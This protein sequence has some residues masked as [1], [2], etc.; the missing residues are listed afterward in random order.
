MPK[1]K[2]SDEHYLMEQ[3]EIPALRANWAHRPT[4]ER[5]ER[6]R[7]LIDKGFSRRA[8]ARGLECSEGLIRQLLQLESL[9]EDEKQALGE[10]SLSLKKALSN[11]H[12]R[13]FAESQCRPDPDEPG[14]ATQAELPPAAAESAAPTANPDGQQSANRTEV[15]TKAFIDWVSNLNLTGPYLQ[16]LFAELDGG[17]RGI[18][19][20]LFARTKPRPE[21]ISLGGD[22]QKVI[23]VCRPKREIPSDPGYISYCVEWYGRWS[24]RL[25]PASKMRHEV[26]YSVAG[27]F[28]QKKWLV[29]PQSF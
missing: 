25:M 29:A 20:L 18:N 9:T 17:P 13:K 23:D 15:V 2:I 5:V 7:A 1:C 3:S 11:V 4:M 27:Y 14:K 22:P 24:R 16:S 6:L 21:E 12:A 10:G 26:L 8:I 19:L 28:H